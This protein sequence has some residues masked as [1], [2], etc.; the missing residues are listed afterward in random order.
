MIKNSESKQKAVKIQRMK[1]SVEAK[2]IDRY[3]IFDKK[4]KVSNMEI[5]ETI[6]EL[7]YLTHSH[8]RYYGKF[9][10]KLA[11]QF[12]D[13]YM[14]DSSV[15]LDNYAGSG[16]SLVEAK[17]RGIPSYGIDINPLAVLACNVKTNVYKK[18]E[19]LHFFEN[20]KTEIEESDKFNKS[21]WERFMPEWNNLSK[22]FDQDV[23]KKL[24]ILK[25]ILSRID[26][27]DDSIR[28]FFWLGYFGIIRR[29][30][31]AH[32]AEVRPHINKDKR[33]REAYEAYV[34]KMTEMIANASDFGD[35]VS[36]KVASK[37]FMGSNTDLSKFPKIKKAGINLTLSHP[38]YLNCFD[39]IP[40][41]SLEFQWGV[42]VPFIWGDFDYETIKKMET[43]SWPATTDKILFGYFDANKKVYEELYKI[44]KPGG[45]CGIVIG[46][47]TINK[48]LI[49][50][51][52]ILASICEDIG[53][54][55]VEIIYRTTHYGTG[56]YAYKE[57]ADYHANGDTGKKDG[58]LVF[59][60]VA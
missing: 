12:L 33:K 22:W 38:P 11:A 9:P 42:G 20:I 2:I 31:N 43:K 4:V 56:K 52:K 46:D 48:E 51:H 49:R 27:K 15:F 30:S 60:K 3:G 47:S 55:L 50:V 32:D 45:V 59:K 53:F 5:N 7:S 18:T 58:I 23:I 28:D 21:E 40:V 24:A 26:F 35:L 17:L 19:L 41:Y 37:T 36:G 44:M 25:L 54:K 13:K 34:K 39:Y 16:T 14:S 57:R 6:S 29:V 8:F 1:D 10:S